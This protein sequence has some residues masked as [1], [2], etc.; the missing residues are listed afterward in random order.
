MFSLYLLYF[1]HY[2]FLKITQNHLIN[3][4]NFKQYLEDPEMFSLYLLYFLHNVFLKITHD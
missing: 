2:V 3:L 1:L 4:D